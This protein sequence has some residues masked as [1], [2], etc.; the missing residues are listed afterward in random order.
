MGKGLNIKAALDFYNKTRG[1]K[2]TLGELAQK[3][4]PERG[5]E[6]A[7]QRISRLNNG[8]YKALT[9]DELEGI[10][11]H[12][13]TDLNFLFEWSPLACNE[14]ELTKNF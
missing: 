6:C 2:M 4:Y 7:A 1:A 9:R 5:A 11:R 13:C 10:A 12:T 3:V 14:T 8:K